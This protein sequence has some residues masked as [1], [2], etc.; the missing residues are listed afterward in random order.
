MLRG[1]V[2]DLLVQRLDM[3]LCRRLLGDVE[4]MARRAVHLLSHITTT[5]S[6][7]VRAYLSR[8]AESY[9]FG[10]STEAAVMI[11][12]VVEAALDERLVGVAESEVRQSISGVDTRHGPNLRQKIEFAK[13]KGW[14]PANDRTSETGS[15]Y[16]VTLQLK[17]QGDQAVHLSPGLEQMEASIAGLVRV[18]EALD[19]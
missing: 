6:E 4:N 7:R 10:L 12:S 5:Q 17:E 13:T 18:L 1:S 14:L 3:D 16:E 2:R 19:V 15:T 11:R 8:V 9:I